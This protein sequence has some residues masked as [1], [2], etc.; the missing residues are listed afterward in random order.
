[1]GEAAGGAAVP[2]EEAAVG[3]PLCFSDCYPNSGDGDCFPVKSHVREL[4]L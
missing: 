4:I 2:R 3:D 1:M